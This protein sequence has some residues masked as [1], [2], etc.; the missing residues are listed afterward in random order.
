MIGAFLT[1]VCARNL[2]DKFTNNYPISQQVSH[3]RA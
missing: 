3:S 2:S 1:Y